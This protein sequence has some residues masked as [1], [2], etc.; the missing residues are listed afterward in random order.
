[1]SNI[2]R[3]AKDVL[4]RVRAKYRDIAKT[5]IVN[6]LTKYKELT[7][8]ADKYVNEFGEY[9][10]MCSLTGTLPVLYKQ[11]T[12]NIPIQVYLPDDFPYKEPICYVR[13]TPVMSINVSETVDSSGKINV[14][15][16]TSW[17]KGSELK[18]LFEVIALKFGT[19]TPVYNK[20]SG[21]RPASGS[22]SQTTPG[23]GGYPTTLPPVQN[24][25]Q[26]P[27]PSYNTPNASSSLPY[28]TQNSYPNS[29]PT[30]YPQAIAT[31][32]TNQPQFSPYNPYTPSGYVNMP[33]ATFPNNQ[34]NKPPV[35]PP[36]T[37]YA[38]YQQQPRPAQQTQFTSNYS[39]ETLKP[40]FAKMSLISAVN[41]KARKRYFEYKEQ[42]DA[43]ID[44]LKQ[45]SNDLEKGKGQ[46]NGI[47]LDAEIE[48]EN[49]KK[50]TQEIKQ[51]TGQINENLSK[52]KHR[53][54][55]DI[56]DAVIALAP[57][58]RQ[59]MQLFAEEMAI[60]DLI[61]YLNEGLSHKTVSLESYLKQTRVLSRKLFMTRAL[62][63]KCRETANLRT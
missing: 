30:P 61:Y 22:F 52:M 49:I 62:I 58:Y 56:D 13:P 18:M 53:E 10:D 45:T 17:R 48:I 26:P 12:Y 14:P 35:P 47:V 51:K 37:A 11:N 46:I 54:K 31:A 21:M 44:S 4:E 63:L 50:Y 3:Q 16:L 42:L 20:S 19:V 34:V 40:E 6:A 36:P 23:G 38:S 8:I 60:Q 29:I 15:Y 57:L 5:Q 55:S 41:D 7:P 43:E 59:I 32:A 9:K 27:Y 2:D 33:C 28:P 25:Q 1:M 39:D 24:Q